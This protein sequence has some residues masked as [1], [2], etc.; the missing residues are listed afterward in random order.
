MTLKQW[1]NRS[2][3]KQAWRAFYKSEAGE[4]LKQVLIFLGIPTPTMPPLNVDFVDWNASLNTRREGFF[5]AIRL[6][7]ALCEDE[8]APDELP[9]PW[10]KEEKPTE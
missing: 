7:S 6:L 3:Y 5:E 4:A 10:E 9:A 2:D 1:N 8:T